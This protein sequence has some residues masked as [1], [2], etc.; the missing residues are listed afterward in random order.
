MPFVFLLYFIPS[1]YIYF[2]IATLTVLGTEELHSLTEDDAQVFLLPNW[3]FIWLG[4]EHGMVSQ[5]TDVIV[6]I[7]EEFK[8]GF[9]KYDWESK[10]GNNG[11]VHFM[12][13]I[14]Y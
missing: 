13:Q 14:S 12:V 11:D 9:N 5:R 1:S 10:E 3:P 8:M 2:P 6:R 7:F 4:M